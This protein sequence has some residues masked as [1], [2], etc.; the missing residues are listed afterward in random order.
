MSLVLRSAQDEAGFL[1]V[2]D[3]AR[4]RILYVSESV[5]KILNY[6]QRDLFG[7]SLFDVLH[8]KDIA[9]VKEQLSSSSLTQPRERVSESKKG[10]SKL[11]NMN[12]NSPEST[13][14][15]V[16]SLPW[17]CP[18]ARRSFF[19]RMKAKPGMVFKEE[20]EQVRHI[21]KPPWK[22]NN[23]CFIVIAD[24]YSQHS[25]INQILGGK[26]FVVIL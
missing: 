19:C 18:G 14:A 13:A 3:S 11:G 17:L 1:F 2:V 16:S 10:G 12:V 7:Q 26:Q 23:S 24:W 20:N 5:S 8:P 15:S 21:L 4:G 25:K 6:T 9:K 22:K